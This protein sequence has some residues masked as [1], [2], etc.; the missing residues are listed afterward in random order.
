[1]YGGLTIT[2]TFRCTRARLRAADHCLD[3]IVNEHRLQIGTPERRT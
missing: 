3:L 2:R 1:M